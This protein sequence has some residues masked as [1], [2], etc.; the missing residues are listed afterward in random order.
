MAGSHLEKPALRAVKPRSMWEYG[1]V[2]FAVQYTYFLDYVAGND[3]V[4]KI[5]YEQLL[6][7]TDTTLKR[8]FGYTFEFGVLIE[9]VSRLVGVHPSPAQWQRIYACTQSDSQAGTPLSRAAIGR[10]KVDPLPIHVERARRIAYILRLPQDFLMP[11]FRFDHN[12]PI[13]D[14]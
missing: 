8:I 1:A 9:G 12:A 7:D 13:L 5:S 6:A 11:S 3:S 14:D 4:M 10:S 2:M